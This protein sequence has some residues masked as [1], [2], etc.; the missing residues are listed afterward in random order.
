MK[1][2]TLTELSR[3]FDDLKT[4]LPFKRM[5]KLDLYDMPVVGA[6][7]VVTG[8]YETSHAVKVMPDGYVFV[9]DIGGFS[10]GENIDTNARDL[11]TV[12]GDS[13]YIRNSA[14]YDSEDYIHPTT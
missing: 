5:P 8:S 2:I 3:F 11:A 9:K 1:Q 4:Y 10:G 6:D 13:K 14:S 7:I 12:V